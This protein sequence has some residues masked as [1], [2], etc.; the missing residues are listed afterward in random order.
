MTESRQWMVL[1]VAVITAW[2]IYLLAPILTPFAV[3]ALFAYLGDPVTDWLQKRGLSRTLAVSVVFVLLSVLVVG[4]L[5]VLLPLL[6]D[7]LVR[8][9]EVLPAFVDWA[10]NAAGP[11]LERLESAGVNLFDRDR[12]VT[13]LQE[14]FKEATDIASTVV[15]SFA[16]SGI[17]LVN[18]IMNLVLIPVVAFYLLRDWDI[19]MARIRE[20]LPRRLEPTVVTLASESNSVLGAFLRGQLTVMVALGVV[21]SIG[22]WLVGLDLAILVGMTAGLISFVPYL[23]AIVG[24]VLGV[25]GALF[26]YGDL[27]HVA[28]VL[29]VFGVGQTLEGVVLTPLLVGDRIGLHPVAVIFAV[30]AGGQLFGF[31]GV[32]LALPVASVVMVLLRHAHSS[33]RGSGLYDEVNDI[34]PSEPRVVLPG[35]AKDKP[36]PRGKG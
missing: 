30:L 6:E 13:M 26:Q 1:V 2:L 8:L 17:A 31:L 21:Y 25:V 23:G 18:W 11:L 4:L 12:L 5:L 16:R 29:V 7:Q 36:E 33:Y 9:V 24:V 14:H 15:G 19:I 22:L 20:L 32:L 10:K 28:M 27:F 34:P 35:S 3:A